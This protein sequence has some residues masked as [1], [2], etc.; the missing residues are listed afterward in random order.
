MVSDYYSSALSLLLNQRGTRI[1]L[2]SS[3]ATVKAD[4]IAVGTRDLSR[5]VK[6]FIGSVS[7]RVLLHS[8]LPTLIVKGKARPVQVSQVNQH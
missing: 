6:T 3:A 5:M 4:L 2:K 7:H 1:A 8:T